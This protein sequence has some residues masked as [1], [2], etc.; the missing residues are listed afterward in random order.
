[1]K[2][3]FFIASLLTFMGTQVS[4]AFLINRQEW[5]AAGDLVQAGFVQGVYA[6]MTQRL[7]GEPKSFTKMKED[8]HAC[9]IS[10][11]LSSQDFIKIIE[12][13]YEDLENWDVPAHIA[14]RQGLFK[15]CKLK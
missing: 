12:R 14:F 1:M 10:M 4:A 6:E 5:N 15:V 3:I 2:Q 11:K 13:H 8:I 9:V 7:G